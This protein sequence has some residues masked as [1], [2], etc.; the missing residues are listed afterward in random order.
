VDPGDF[1]GWCGKSRSHW[2]SYYELSVGTALSTC[3]RRLT[4]I[5]I[6]LYSCL[7][8]TDRINLLVFIIVDVRLQYF[9]LYSISMDLKFIQLPRCCSL[10]GQ[11]KQKWLL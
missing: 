1:L 4:C 6:S 7:L 3:Y 10:F 11:F 8:A 5:N 9:M 2:D